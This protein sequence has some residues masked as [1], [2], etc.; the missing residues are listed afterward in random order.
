MNQGRFDVESWPDVNRFGSSFGAPVV[1][2]RR[3]FVLIGSIMLGALIGTGCRLG[4]TDSVDFGSPEPA[5]R[6]RA[7]RAAADRRDLTA[8]PLL[9]DRLEDEDEAVRFYAIAALRRLTA[10]DHGYRYYH[11]AAARD[12]AVKRW[13][14]ALEDPDHSAA[15]PSADSDEHP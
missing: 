13:R 8:V 11:P 3:R 6:I 1:P 2:D 12:R 15:E 10:R 5:S 7:I 14:Q 4:L 9:V